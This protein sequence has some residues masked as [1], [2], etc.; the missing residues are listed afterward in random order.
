MVEGK[1]FIPD[2]RRLLMYQ[3]I[4]FLHIL[5][6]F[7]FLLAHGGSANVAFRL[8]RE[9]DPERVRALLDLSNSNFSLMY[10]S[11][12]VL[13]IA[14]IVSGFLG[15]WWGFGWIWVSL[16]LLIVI[17]VVMYV[18]STASFNRIRKAVGLTYF[19][20]G[21]PHPAQ[22]AASADE[23]NKVLESWNPTLSIIIGLGGLV[24]ILWL[25]MFKP[26]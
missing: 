7:G 19:E 8:R 11:L 2:V 15:R 23:I 18:T 26:F 12:L 17:A 16:G 6:A 22:D 10:L 9:R 14:G 1:K 13:L 24:A 20:G 4:V 5:G 3:W 21:K 25:M